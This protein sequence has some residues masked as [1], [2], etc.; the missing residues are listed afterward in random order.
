MTSKNTAFCTLGLVSCA[1]DADDPNAA[2][3]APSE[4]TEA[5]KRSDLM[6]LLA[7]NET[8]RWR[9][10]ISSWTTVSVVVSCQMYGTSHE[11]VME[12]FVRL[13]E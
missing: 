8:A 3:L 7:Y 9:V 4:R 5:T 12:E 1:G 13:Q 6:D 2:Y 10:A 11:V